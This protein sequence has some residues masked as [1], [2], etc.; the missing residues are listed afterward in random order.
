MGVLPMP[1]NFLEVI[2]VAFVFDALGLFDHVLRAISSVP[3]LMF[4]LSG[5]LTFTALGLFLLLKDAAIGWD[6]RK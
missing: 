5:M 6:R 2:F 1:L 4:F 3:L